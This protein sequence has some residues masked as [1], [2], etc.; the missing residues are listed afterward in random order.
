[1][2]I[3]INKYIGRIVF[4]IKWLTWSPRERYAYLWNR[5]SKNLQTGTSRYTLCNLEDHI[6]YGTSC[7]YCNVSAR[8]LGLLS[9]VPNSGNGRRYEDKEI[10]YGADEG[11]HSADETTRV[12]KLELLRVGNA[13]EGES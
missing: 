6:R 7:Q 11:R 8:N 9:S 3:I 10:G 13:D 5:T 2:N 1:M 12:L 4:R